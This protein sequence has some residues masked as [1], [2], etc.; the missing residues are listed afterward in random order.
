[1]AGSSDLAGSL[2]RLSGILVDVL[3]DPWVSLDCATAVASALHVAAQLAENIQLPILSTRLRQVASIFGAYDYQMK[4]E[5]YID[6]SPWPMRWSEGMESIIRS[7][8]FIKEKEKQIEPWRGLPLRAAIAKRVPNSQRRPRRRVAIV[9]VCD[10]D[11]GRTPLARLSQINKAKYAERHGYDIK[12]YEKAPVLEDPLTPLLTDKDRP[13]AWSKV[14]AIL[15][16]LAAGRHDWVMWMDCDSFFMDDEVRLE[17]V[18][19]LAEDRCAAAGAAAGGEGDDLADLR[20]FVRRWV[21]GPSESL[22]GGALTSWYD[23]L[24][25]SDWE[26]RRASAGACDTCAACAPGGPCDECLVGSKPP[27]NRTLGWTDWLFGETR[28]QLLASEDGLMLNTGIVLVRASAWSWTFFQKVRWMTFGSSPVTQHPWWEQTAMVYLL[29]VP[30]VVAHLAH[31]AASTPASPPR[32]LGARH[33]AHWGHAPAS[34]M[35][36]QKHINAYPPLVASALMTHASFTEGD[37]IVSFSGC[38]IYSS[39]EV[40]NQLFLTYFAAVHGVAALEGDP[41]LAPWL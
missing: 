12:I 3:Q 7:M 22:S 32:D 28:P 17:E 19:A 16:A 18:F 25:D 41:A 36:S 29:Q 26:R 8:I 33:V 13:A 37:F 4:G 27:M 15:I 38:K 35:F 1:M 9:S 10:Y 2:A 21:A 31:L 20:A 30:F 14:D 5:E 40:C 39:Q 24:I 6:Q 23:G 34:F 11:A